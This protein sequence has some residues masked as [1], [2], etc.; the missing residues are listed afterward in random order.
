MGTEF[1]FKHKKYLSAAVIPVKTGI[2][3]LKPQDSHFRGDD[4]E[5][6]RIFDSNRP[7]VFFTSCSLFFFVE[8]LSYDS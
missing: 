2:H 1:F 7:V 6:V 5:E 3:P 4:K 8:F